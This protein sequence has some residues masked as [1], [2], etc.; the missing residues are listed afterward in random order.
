[1]AEEAEATNGRLVRVV[2][3]K[4][5][6]SKQ[7]NRLNRTAIS[8]S[9]SNGGISVFTANCAIG[10]SGTLCRHIDAYYPGVAGVPACYWPFEPGDYFPAGWVVPTAGQG[11]PPDPCHHEIFGYRA[12]D[13]KSLRAIVERIPL[14]ALARC[15][16]DRA[17]PVSEEDL[18]DCESSNG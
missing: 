8:P 10:I 7:K 16:G 15:D 5:H 18:R 9:S 13:K 11:E 2:N 3:L 1:M 4:Y 17:V 6:Y 14:S 12:S